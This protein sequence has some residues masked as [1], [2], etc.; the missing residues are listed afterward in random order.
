M[1]KNILIT[2]GSRGIGAACA[3][4]FALEGYN[5]IIN[6]N[7][8]SESARS[9]QKSITDSGYN[10]VIARADVRSREEV[11]RMIHAIID[12]YGHIDV[13][14]NNAG[15]AQQKLFD[16]I[17]ISDWNNMIETNLTGVF[18]CT[19][20]VLKHMLKEHSGSIVNVSSLWGVTG[21]SCEVHYSA[22]KAGVIGLT[23]A[24]A[25]EVAPS[26]I[27]VNCVAPGV[28]DTDMNSNLTIDDIQTLCEET[29]LGR[30]GTPEEVAK[31]V[32]FLAN[33]NSSF[34]TG[35]VLEVNGGINI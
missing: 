35:Q 1:G 18:N 29:P 23:K 16:E 34:I 10:A 30:M 25:K 11:D 3:I 22:A 14:V 26:G 4:L 32:L 24:L 21:G 7:Y 15:I 9:L 17:T 5:V 19:Q 27:R 13:L 33:E 12:K 31:A 2:G 28:I 6:Y 8:S 20:S